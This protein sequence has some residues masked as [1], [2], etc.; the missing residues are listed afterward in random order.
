MDETGTVIGGRFR[1]ERA[2]GAG[3]RGAVFQAADLARGGACLVRRLPAGGEGGAAVIARTEAQARA[4]S[5]LDHPGLPRLI[6]FGM[7]EVAGVPTITLV[8][9]WAPGRDL[10]SLLAEGF[11]PDEAQAVGLLLAATHPLAYLHSL[12]PPLAHGNLT[13]ANLVVAEGGGV[14]LTDPDLR[15]AVLPAG[16][17]APGEAPWAAP[18]TAHGRHGPR[19]DIHALGR[20]MIRA[21]GGAGAAAP[22]DLRGLG[23]SERLLRILGWMV[24]PEENRRY[25]IGMLQQDLRDHRASLGPAAPILP[26][27]KKPAP[28]TRGPLRVPPWILP[29]VAVTIVFGV[30]LI[31]RE[32]DRVRHPVPRQ[33]SAPAAPKTYPGA[34][35][36]S[37]SRPSY[38]PGEPIVVRYDGL[39]GSAYDWV[40]IVEAGA[41][42]KT[43]REW[44]YAEGHTGGEMTFQGLPAGEYQ[45][46]AFFDWPDGGYVVR[47]RHDFSVTAESGPVQV[48]GRLLHDGR[49]VTETSPNQAVFWFR[50]EQENVVVTPAVEQQGERFTIAGLEPG[51]YFLSVRIDTDGRLGGTWPG[52]LD[53]GTTFTLEE[54]KPLDLEVALSRIIQLTAPVDSGLPIPGWDGLCGESS[55]RESPVTFEW[56]ALGAGI[57]YQTQIERVGCS[58]GSHRT[59]DVP[60]REETGGT[61]V[62]IELPPSG[63]D[64]YYAFHLGATRE[65]R[66]VGMITTHGERG[67]L[68]WD[69]RFRVQR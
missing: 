31:R 50:N 39:P 48:R 51:D 60:F 24:E 6:D 52:D 22:E 61:S 29:L 36:L 43:Y 25:D 34:A 4:L 9:S 17:E 18:E 33:E 27:A 11:R 69:Y 55:S 13:P 64:E 12:T 35:S 26:P 65:G 10:G 30:A 45:V 49:P 16:G 5:R 46:R 57:M 59:I 54:G 32:A 42:E 21:L 15:G 19:A 41:A 67:G 3:S 53:G 66:R 63:A 1:L 23:L 8:T 14:V 38:A 62:T 58:G 44:H 37:T 2:I 56:Q 47:G 68:G 28:P 20:I 40:T 7:A